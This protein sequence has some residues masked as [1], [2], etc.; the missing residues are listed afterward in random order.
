MSEVALVVEQSARRENLARFLEFV[1]DAC[2]RLNADEAAA[3]AVRLAV[4]EVCVNLIDYGYAGAP[5]GPIRIE[6]KREGDLLSVAITDRGAPFHPDQ[7]PAP[8]L[9]SDVD[10]RPIGGLGWHLVK[11]MV[12]QLAYRTDAACGNRLTF[13][14]RSTLKEGIG[15]GI[16]R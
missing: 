11:N 4:E 15:N 6:V 1:D 5:P 10:Q 2:Q 16:V 9:S 14:K 3:Y 7:A 13:T 8:D 12:D